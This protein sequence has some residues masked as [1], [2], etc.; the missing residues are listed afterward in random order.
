MQTGDTREVEQ[1]GEE[2][3]RAE[4]GDQVAEGHVEEGLQ[5]AAALEAADATAR[6]KGLSRADYELLHTLAGTESVSEDLLTT[7]AERLS[8]DAAA[9]EL[10][11]EFTLIPGY[12][13]QVSAGHGTFPSADEKPSRK[14]AFRRKWL[15]YRGLS[16]KDLV[17]VFA[18]GDSME[19]TI[20][21]NNTL[22]IDTSNTDLSNGQI[23]VIRV[24]SH[25]VAK[26][27]QTLTN[28]DIMLLS[29]NE[30]YKPEVLKPEQLQDLAV[31][32]KVVW[33][34]KDV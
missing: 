8:V 3:C 25:L 13:V 9:A 11:M 10:A 12:S 32:G 1:R 15:K 7:L 21:D 34:G 27:V 6:G 19:P 16:E 29:D 33:I 20:S 31:I 22:M 26:R 5:R 17:L 28:R 30:T 2:H 24:N 4:A 14:L 18:K 23:Y